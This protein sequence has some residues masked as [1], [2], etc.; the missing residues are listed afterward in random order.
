MGLQG[1]NLGLN[2][3]GRG[4]TGLHYTRG[5]IGNN[6]AETKEQTLKITSDRESLDISTKSASRAV[7]LDVVIEGRRES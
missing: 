7:G 3:E 2:S 5:K 4:A 6:G 1:L